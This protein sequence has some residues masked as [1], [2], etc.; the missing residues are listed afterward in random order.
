MKTDG[1]IFRRVHVEFKDIGELPRRGVI[2]SA[3]HEQANAVVIIIRYAFGDIRNLNIVDRLCARFSID[4]WCFSFHLAK[5]YVVI[6]SLI[7]M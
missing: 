3:S 6:K 7:M 5:I 2:G 4:T 1:H